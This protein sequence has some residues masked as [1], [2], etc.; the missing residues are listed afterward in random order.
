MKN[1]IIMA[2]VLF[3][4]AGLNSC[5]DSL[6]LDDYQKE[7][8]INKDTVFLEQS[9]DTVRVIDTVTTIVKDT[10]IHNDTTVQVISDTIWRTYYPLMVRQIVLSEFHQKNGEKYS[11][12]SS[13]PIPPEIQLFYSDESMPKLKMSI[14]FN[15]INNDSANRKEYV[16]DVIIET[17]RIPL[18]LSKTYNLNGTKT[19]GRY[20]YI[21]IYHEGDN[22]S[23]SDL[24]SPVNLKIYEPS[25]DINGKP[26]S[27]IIEIYA[28]INSYLSNY[29]KLVWRAEFLMQYQQP[30]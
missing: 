6:G 5:D 18:T 28:V 16:K 30:F 3:I 21:N 2:A 11:H 19:S 1:L 20:S 27:Q 25:T 29:D 22:S 7:Q 23:F 14:N 15:F 8:I 4:I 13:Y 10:V 12:P 9:P 17:D 26:V 24:N